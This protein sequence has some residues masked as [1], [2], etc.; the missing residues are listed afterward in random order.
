VRVTGAAIALLAFA[1]ATSAAASVNPQELY[2]AGKYQAAIDA[3]ASQGSASSLAI[4]A[5]ATLAETTLRGVS[6]LECIGRAEAYA[7][8]AIALDP[9]RP[10]GHLY[11]AVALG[12]EA[13]IRGAVAARLRGLVEEAKANLD[14][15]LAADPDN[16]R[17]LAAL[18]GWNIAVAG[19]AGATLAHWLYGASFSEGMKDFTRAFRLA[20]QDI[21]LR[22]QYALSLS[23]YDAGT[24]HK[25]IET[26]L[27]R[28]IDGKPATAYDMESQKRARELLRLLKANDLDGLQQAVR[29]YQG[30][31]PKATD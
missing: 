12:Y 28:V 17:V 14:A 29:R 27:S 2:A 24:Y 5:H 15:A 7:R 22:Y 26:S 4:A 9:K 13:R 23:G 11:L 19:K 20:P 3:G 16:A 21:A 10:E 31:P 1:G 25:E 30:Y 18:G 6:C 8:R